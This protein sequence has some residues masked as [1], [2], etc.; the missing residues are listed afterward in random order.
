MTGA[1]I[2]SIHTLRVEGDPSPGQ[3]CG[4]RRISIHTLRV[5]GDT[6]TGLHAVLTIISI[7]TLRVE[8]DRRTCPPCWGQQYFNPH[9]P[10]GG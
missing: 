2:I 5:E 1:E 8:G 6:I 10:R 4:R 7:H 9:P 3:R